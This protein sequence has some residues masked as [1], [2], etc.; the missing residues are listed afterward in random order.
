MRDFPASIAGLLLAGG[1]MVATQSFAADSAQEGASQDD[2]LA[3]VVVTA[4]APQSP[5]TFVTDPQLPRQPVPASDGA[6]YLKTIPGFSAVRNGGTNGDPVLRG[7]FGSRL[8]ILTNDGSMPGACPARMDNP[9]SYV[10]PETYDRLVVIKGPQ[11]V[12]WG[13]GASAGT[14]RFERDA[15]ADRFEEA[16]LRVNANA[17]GG[18]FGRNDQVLDIVGGASPGYARLSASRSEADDYEDGEGRAVPSS[19]EKW[20]ADAALGWTP[21]AGT[22]LE[23]SAGTGDGE[24]R[25]AGRGMDGS[26]FERFSYGLRFEKTGLTGALKDVKANV[27]YNYADHVMDNY[28]LREPNPMSS[29]PMP[30]A[31]NVD[32]RTTGG[33]VAAT[34]QLASIELT[35]G[36]DT[37][38]S[39]HRERS[40][41]GRAAYARQP[42]QTDAEIANTGIFAELGW[43]LNEAGRAVVGG[44]ADRAEVADKRQTAGG[45]MPMPNPTADDTRRE[46][47]ASGF[48]RYEHDAR[49][50]PISWFAGVGRVERMPDYWE[51]FSP[52]R[53]PMGT[54]N[55]FAALDPEQTMQL[56]VGLQYRTARL[57]VWASAYAGRIDDFILFAYSSGGMMGLMS[58]VAQVDAEVRGG[59]AGIEFRPLPHWKVGTTLAYAWAENRDLGTALPQIPPLDARFA[60]TYDNT[61]WSAGALLRAVDGQDRVAPEQ[62]NVVGRDLGKT[63]G[64]V[65]L[66]LNGAY[67]FS[68]QLSLAAGIDNLLDRDYPEHLNLA[69]SADFGYPADPVRIHEPG[70][71]AWLKVLWNMSGR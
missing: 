6:D 31:A 26:Q 35:A 41:M 67:R 18:S 47:L 69:G 22:L 55:A 28:T 44:R 14:I 56:D 52:D 37:Q 70:R 12:L 10:S 25:Y 2:P 9:L 27:F 71:T 62:G 57:N 58:S 23:F 46:T 65:V 19:W 53:G 4:V 8:N 45:M 32:R 15:N 48:V 40:A 42:W 49:D 11:T 30:M 17:L 24:A 63:A 3:T 54:V 34:W 59:E 20:N 1:S 5:L 50:T 33:R 39:R 7:M 16:G 38:D 43:R 68:P 60:L 36:A 64:F 61:R 21:S 13:P 51:L 66:S 29:M